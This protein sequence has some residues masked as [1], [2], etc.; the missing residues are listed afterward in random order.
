MPGVFVGS[1]P[2]DVLVKIDLF[3]EDDVRVFEDGVDEGDHIIVG[4]LV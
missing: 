1:W 3:T 2:A 4:M